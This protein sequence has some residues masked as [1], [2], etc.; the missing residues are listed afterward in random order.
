MDGRKKP[1]APTNA[2]FMLVCFCIRA[3]QMFSGLTSG[4]VLA[5][6]TCRSDFSVDGKVDL[7]LWESV[8]LKIQVFSCVSHLLCSCYSNAS[9]SSERV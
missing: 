6:L 1:P 5:S 4:G 8:S 2:S 3:L 9:S 7:S